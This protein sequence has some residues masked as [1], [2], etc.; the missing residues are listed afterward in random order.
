MEK[1]SMRIEPSV[2]L[3]TDPDL[4]KYR[5]EIKNINSFRF[6]RKAIESEIVRQREALDRGEKIIQETRGFVESKGVT[7]G[8]RE[9]E[10][11][12]DYRYFPEPDIPP[13]RFAQAQIAKIKAQIGELPEEKRKRFIKQY[14]LSDYDAGQLTETRER[15]EFFEEVAKVGKPKAI[16]NIIINKKVQTKEDLMKL[17]QNVPAVSV[18]E[19]QNVIEKILKEN[20]RAIEDY[21]KG[22]EQALMFLMGQVK[23]KLKGGDSTQILEALK[24]S[25]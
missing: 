14:G 7:V 4:P 22:K 13:M 1:G 8:Q 10:E 3:R 18:E 19:L 2:S 23:R 15:A 9:K 17:L 24:R 20:S 25:L 16:A 6:V 5:V 11:A 21:K 12:H